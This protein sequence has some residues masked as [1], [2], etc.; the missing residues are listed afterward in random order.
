MVMPICL[1]PLVALLHCF[2]WIGT[3]PVN[4]LADVNSLST[5]L[6]SN[7]LCYPFGVDAAI[8]AVANC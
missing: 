5:V 1:P 2:W 7:F 4:V 3:C 6:Q 8:Q